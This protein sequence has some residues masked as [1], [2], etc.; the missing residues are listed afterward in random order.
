MAWK[1]QTLLMKSDRKAEKMYSKIKTNITQVLDHVWVCKELKDNLKANP[2]KQS[3]PPPLRP[4]RPHAILS[5]L[6]SSLPPSFSLSPCQKSSDRKGGI[7]FFLPCWTKS[8]QSGQGLQFSLFHR[9][10]SFFLSF[11]LFFCTLPPFCHLPV[12]L[13]PYETPLR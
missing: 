5:L 10:L 7:K 2:L 3:P 4:T 9:S 13:F 8:A 1:S 6:L 12:F 11:F